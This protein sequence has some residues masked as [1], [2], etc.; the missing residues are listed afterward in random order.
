MTPITRRS[1]AFCGLAAAL[2][3]PAFGRKLGVFGLQLYTVRRIIDQ[4]PA[5][6]IAG[7]AGQNV[8]VPKIVK[9]FDA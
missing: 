1:F 3:A 4:D 7:M 5:K 2:A 8:V 9:P 6:F